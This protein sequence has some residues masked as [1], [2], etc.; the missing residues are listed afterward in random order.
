[1]NP[2]E[3]GQALVERARKLGADE[4]E[5]FVQKAATVQIEIRD[6]QAET[7]TYRDR[8]GYGLRV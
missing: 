1:M 3:I 6:G 2:L 8:N 4:A 5:A 7:V